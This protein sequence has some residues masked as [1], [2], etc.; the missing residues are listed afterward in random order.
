MIS[1]RRTCIQ[2]REPTICMYALRS[3]GVKKADADGE[4]LS[5]SGSRTSYAEVGIGT[6]R[7]VLCSCRKKGG[8]IGDALGH[9]NRDET[10]R[11]V[12]DDLHTEEL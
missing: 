1:G 6:L 2:I 4:R 9:A 5:K 12:A 11:S 8:E 10:A 3:G 7:G